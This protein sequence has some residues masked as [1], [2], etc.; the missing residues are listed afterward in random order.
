MGRLLVVLKARYLVELWGK[1]EVELWAVQMVDWLAELMAVASGF[2]MGTWR[3]VN[4]AAKK[5]AKL[6][7]CLAKPGV[8]SSDKWLAGMLGW[9]S[10]AL[11]VVGKVEQKAGE[12]VMQLVDAMVVT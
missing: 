10:A 5:V 1:L 6:V 3:A 12:R 2:Q 11:M 7:V 4:M 8:A 9:K